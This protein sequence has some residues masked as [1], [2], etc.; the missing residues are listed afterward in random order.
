MSKSKL[1]VLTKSDTKP[2]YQKGLPFSCTECGKC[3]TGAPGYVWL[4]AKEM[5]TIANFLKI[6][7]QEFTDQ[8]LRKIGNRFSLRED[9]YSFDCVFLKGKGCTIYPVRP[10]QCRTFPWWPENLESEED[11]QE[12]SSY[13]EGISDDAPLVSCTEIEK[14]LFPKNTK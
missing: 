1:S 10:T 12:A 8:Y 6:S 13:C 9:P 11:W 7:I 2:W 4:N 14:H 3:C 5:E